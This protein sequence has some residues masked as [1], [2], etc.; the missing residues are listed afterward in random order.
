MTS[1]L[2]LRNFG[3]SPPLFLLLGALAAL[4]S[5]WA[6]DEDQGKAHVSKHV[7]DMI[8]A[9]F[10]QSYGKPDQTAPASSPI[11]NQ[12]KPLAEPDR[13]V[14][15]LAPFIISEDRGPKLTPQA[16]KVDKSQGSLPGTGLTEFKGKHVTFGI[17]RILFIPVA[18]GWSW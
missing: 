5:L 12:P 16:V 4:P 2:S 1:R 9:P 18:F 17:Y 15:H 10:R 11:F 8:L 14:V 6:D 13:E 3:R 7:S